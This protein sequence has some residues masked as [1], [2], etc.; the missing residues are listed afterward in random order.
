MSFVII[1]HDNHI[2]LKKKFGSFKKLIFLS[3]SIDIDSFNNNNLYKKPN[4]LYLVYHQLGLTYENKI[5]YEKFKNHL[6]EK[7]LFEDGNLF[8]TDEINSFLQTK[9]PIKTIYQYF[10]KKRD[11]NLFIKLSEN[12]KYRKTD[13]VHKLLL[14]LHQKN[15]QCKNLEKLKK[16]F[17][18]NKEN[19]LKLEELCLKALENELKAISKELFCPSNN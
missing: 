17:Y 12:L 5:K 11:I 9:D 7:G 18:K 3:E 10:S 13:E 4:K 14:Q 15:P 16:E 8:T 6:E 1:C 19:V 2:Q